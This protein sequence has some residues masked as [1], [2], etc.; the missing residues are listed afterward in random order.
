MELK[1]AS[2]LK[3][4]DIVYFGRI[5]TAIDISLDD[6]PEFEGYVVWNFSNGLVWPFRPGGDKDDRMWEVVDVQLLIDGIRNLTY[7]IREVSP[8]LADQLLD[9]IGDIK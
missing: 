6:R 7:K 4:G 2:E 1:K 3:S 8:L 5:T 9:L